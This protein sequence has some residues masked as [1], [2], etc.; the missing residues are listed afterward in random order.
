MLAGALLAAVSFSSCSTFDRNDVAA[1]VNGVELTNDDLANLA[2]TD[3][4]LRLFNT[5]PPNEGGRERFIATLWVFLQAANEVGALDAI[6]DDAVIPSLDQTFGNDWR[7]GAEAEATLIDAVKFKALLDQQLLP[8]DDIRAALT[9]S[10]VWVS[11][12]V[13]G[14]AQDEFAILPFGS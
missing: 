12:R 11:S 4:L 5:A 9:E 8:V 2:S 13:G 10:E 6:T 3:R 14:W 1:E 7:T